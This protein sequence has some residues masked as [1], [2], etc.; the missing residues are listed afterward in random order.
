M[1]GKLSSRSI[2]YPFFA[3]TRLKTH[4]FEDLTRT[5]MGLG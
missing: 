5:A 4:P 1:I 2:E 3:T